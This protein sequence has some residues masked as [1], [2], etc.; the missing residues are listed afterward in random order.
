MNMNTLQSQKSLNKI[1]PKT[2]SACNKNTFHL[3]LHFLLIIPYKIITH[4]LKYSPALTPRQTHP[5]NPCTEV[6]AHTTSLT[7]IIKENKT[8]LFYRNHSESPVNHPK[9]CPF[10]LNIP[11][12]TFKHGVS[13]LYVRYFH[14]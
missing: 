8:I 5:L 4:Y 11:K 10:F 13:H 1:I 7:A 6:T 3:F 9:P 12:F 14:E 2:T